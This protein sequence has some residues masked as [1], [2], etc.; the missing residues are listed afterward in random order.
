MWLITPRFFVSV[1]EKASD[2]DND[3]LTVRARDSKS[4]S[5]F[6]EATGRGPKQYAMDMATDY[7]YRDVFTREEVATALLASV[8]SIRYSNF[9]NAAKAV[10]GEK[11][12]GALNEVWWAMQRLTPAKVKKK[13]DAMWI[14][15]LPKREGRWSSGGAW[16]KEYGLTQADLFEREDVEG[17]DL[18]KPKSIASMTDAEWDDFM[19]ET[20]PEGYAEGVYNVD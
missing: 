8:V 20:D 6:A 9:K 10:R 16:A 3:T 18:E 11:Y 15:A 7:P 19:R 12:A 1:V 2:V 14:A 17:V 4:L 5:N 13:M